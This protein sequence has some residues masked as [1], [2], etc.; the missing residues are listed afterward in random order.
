MQHY[1]LIYSSFFPYCLLLS[2]SASGL[3]SHVEPKLH[4]HHKLSPIDKTI[5][6]KAYLEEDLGLHVDTQTWEYITEDQYQLLRPVVSNAL[7]SMAL[8]KINKIDGVPDR[9]KYCI[10][11]LGN[12]DP[13]NW[14]S[15]DC[16]TP[17]FSPVEFNLLIALA[18]KSASPK[19]A[20]SAKPSVLPD[21]EQYVICPPKVCP[22]TPSDTYLLLKKTLYG[23]KH[24]PCHWYNTCRKALASL[25]LFL[26]PNAP[27]IF[28]GIIIEGEPPLY[29]GLFV[30]DFIYFSD[31]D[32]VEAAFKTG[33]ASHFTADYQGNITHF[34]GI[35]FTCIREEDDLTI[36]MNQPNDVQELITKAGLLASSQTAPKLLSQSTMTMPL[37]LNGHTI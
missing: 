12:L 3:E 31:S 8:S 11:V 20:M 36:Y 27:C 14:S 34:L 15:A 13:H 1:P 10:V 29:L 30:D 18:T 33:F 4:E 22:L 35:K 16:F 5:W 23:L 2:Y 25:G 17:V 9:A 7:P 26:C 37:P 28:S 6:D 24:S 21:D 32:S 19:L